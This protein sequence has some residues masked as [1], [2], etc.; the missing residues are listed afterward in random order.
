M[1]Y[2]NNVKRKE[3]IPIWQI[4]KSD[5]KSK[6]TLDKVNKRCY[7]NIIKG[8]HLLNERKGI[9]TM[10]KREMFEVIATTMAD[11]EEVVNFCAH[12]VE[13]LDRKKNYKSSKP[14]KK[15]IENDA[16]KA[17]ILAV[18]GESEAPM[19]IGEINE[20]LDKGFTSQKVSALLTQLIKGESVVKTYEKKVAY[21]GLV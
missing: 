13:L 10:T 15:S 2:T 12:E 19:T 16:I 5:T 21:F 7:N 1:C 3:K 20:R 9:N 14:S 18:L 17:D 8:N 11:N 6:K 4:K